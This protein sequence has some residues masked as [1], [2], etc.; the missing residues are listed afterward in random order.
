MVGGG[1]S[2]RQT[3]GKDTKEIRV[4]KKTRGKGISE[5]KKNRKQETK[6][7]KE[8]MKREDGARAVLTAS[9]RINIGALEDRESPGARCYP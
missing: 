1:G 3:V 9:S 5:M 7:E 6:Q 8:R 4:K 2:K